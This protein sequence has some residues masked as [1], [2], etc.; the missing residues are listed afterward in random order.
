MHI[1]D[2]RN[3]CPA[4]NR[5]AGATVVAAT[6]ME[7]DGAATALMVLGE[8]D[9]LAWVNERQGLETLLIIRN[10][11]GAFRSAASPG[12]QDYLEEIFLDE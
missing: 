11:D 9:G 5:V 8:T 7:A 6:C 10:E 4:T 12:F 1:I 3:G 2:P